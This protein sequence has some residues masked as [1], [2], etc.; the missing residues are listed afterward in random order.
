MLSFRRRLPVWYHPD[1]R[2]PIASVEGQVGLEPRRADLACWWLV[3]AGVLEPNE[4]RRPRR[5]RYDEL[6]LVHTHDYLESL[7]DPRTRARIFAVD[8]SEVPVDEVLRSVRLVTGGTIEATREALRLRGPTFNLLGGF[9]HAAP[10]R[11]GG[12]CAVNDIAVAI[13]VVRKAGFDGRVVVLDLDAH[14]PDGTAECLQKDD[15]WIGSISG[16]AWSALEGVDDV[17]LT[18]GD[19]DDICAR[20]SG[21]SGACRTASWCSCW[22]AA[23]CWRAIGWAICAC[24]STAPCA[25]RS[26]GGRGA[27]P[28][29]VGVAAGGRLLRRTRG[30]RWP[31]PRWR[32]PPSRRSGAR[33]RSALDA[34]RRHRARPAARRAARSRA[35]HGGRSGAPA[36]AAAPLLDFYSNEGIEYALTR[37]QLFAYLERLG[38][39]DFRVEVDAAVSGGDRVRVY[40]HA[41]GGEHL[42]VECVLERQALAGAE[43]LYVHWLSLRHPRAKFLPGRP[44]LPGQDVPGL[45]LARE[46]AELFVRIAERL[47]LD[48]VAFR[49]AWYHTAYA[50]RHKLHFVDG[51]RQGR[52]EALM[53]DLGAM[54]LAEATRALAEGR[55]RMDGVLYTWE[56]DPMVHL[57][58]KVEPDSKVAEAR[59]R[60]HFTVVS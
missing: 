13:A 32:W 58:T 8:P 47:G 12:L 5:A 44:P 6:A 22:P 11:G 4:V 41:G 45:G 33:S 46:V 7:S 53:R 16:T 25:A 14:P 60:A 21:C 20:S 35:L 30:R 10:A 56:A 15:A 48:G 9:H 3:E 38:Y 57:R 36:V 40:G 49:P 29:A 34:L 24:R 27:A 39:G 50:A 17:A 37:Y 18:A 1:Y 19:D 31:G 52:F 43:V 2:L 59:E 42:L 28:S 55:V 51:E 54:P 26:G 23:T